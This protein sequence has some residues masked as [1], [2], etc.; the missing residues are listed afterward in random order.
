MTGVGGKA[1]VEPLLTMRLRDG[2]V[3]LRERL[4]D[5]IR[6]GDWSNESLRGSWGAFAAFASS[7]R[8]QQVSFRLRCRRAVWWEKIN[9]CAGEADMSS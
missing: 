1:A 6:F 8:S 7:A 3:P 4:R 2:G 5:T 9:E